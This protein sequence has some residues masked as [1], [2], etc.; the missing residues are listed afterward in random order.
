ME[1]T[2]T[3]NEIVAITTA[4]N[5]LLTS[6]SDHADACCF[7]LNQLIQKIKTEGNAK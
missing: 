3:E 6:E 2:L 1:I 7:Y 4:Y 5:L